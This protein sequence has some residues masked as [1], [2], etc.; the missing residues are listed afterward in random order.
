[1]DTVTIG[2]FGLLA[3]RTN[4][5]AMLKRAKVTL[6]AASSITRQSSPA[7]FVDAQQNL[8]RVLQQSGYHESGTVKLSE[9]LDVWQ[10]CISILERMGLNERVRDVTH[11]CERVRSEIIRRLSA[12]RT[13]NL[14]E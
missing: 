3:E 11:S 12:P 1:M 2:A 9:A 7:D 13:I 8:G 6:R 4:D 5:L 10:E 14:S